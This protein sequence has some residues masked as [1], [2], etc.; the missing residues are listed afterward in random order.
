MAEDAIL[1]RSTAAAGGAFAS[2]FDLELPPEC[3]GWEELYP[4]YVTFGPDLRAADEERFWFQDRLH[5]PEPIYP[6]DELLV[7]CCF[8]A[9]G[10]ANAR[11]FAI[12]P[13]L[14][15]EYR[16]LGGYVYM[17]PNPVED[18]AELASRAALFQRRAGYYFDHWDELHAR[19]R[20]KVVATVQELRELAVPELPEFEPE[21]VV[22]EARGFGSTHELV[23]AFNRL[24]D[25][26]DRV[27]QYHFELL[28]LGYAAYVAL[29]ELCRE[30][31]PDMND[32]TITT[33]VSGGELLVSRPEAEL[34]R[35]AALAQELGLADTVAAGKDEAELRA[36]LSESDPGSR[37]LEALDEAKDPWFCFSYGNGLYS[38]HRSW[39]DDTSLPLALIASYVERLRA[40]ED[41]TPRQNALA[42]ERDRIA[43][44]YRA[45]L[46]RG[47]R[48]AFD[49]SLALARKV[50]PYVENHNFYV[51]HWYLTLFWNKV[52]GFG[53]LLAEHG[54]IAMP[55]DIFCLRHGE[56]RAALDELRLWWSAAGN[57]PLEGRARWPATVAR[58][59]LCLEAM[60]RWVAPPALG[61][62]PEAMADPSMAMLWGVTPQTVREWLGATDSAT[63]L[64]GI[65]GSPGIAEG[66]AR[67]ISSVDELRDIEDGE[68]LVAT[69]SSTSWT[70]VF[71]RLAGVVLDIGGV[72]SHAAVIAR[73]RGLPAVVGAGTATR[74]IRTGDRLR[75]D[76]NAGVVTIL[77]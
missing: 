39:I 31:F 45:L 43:A 29:Y 4:T 58:R 69:S 21:S 73:E 12:P 26:L 56:V 32:G 75:V 24:L 2:P 57:A 48:A 17:S 50:Y 11:L 13:A 28:N 71:G 59:K 38:H 16:L 51:E 68:I 33:L 1:A 35:L 55:D 20:E 66:Q 67:L 37:W 47:R 9:F 30:V 70:P 52:R 15:A 40:G 61:P 42:G 18:Q 14:G 10:Q 54:L 44:E 25:G 19:W 34:R 62:L 53:A 46:P 77:N 7:E 64:T 49:A 65:A 3:E 5:F 36:A 6:F 22:T 8:V 27:L 72:M 63:A 23:A 74:R 76:G 41:I 60:R